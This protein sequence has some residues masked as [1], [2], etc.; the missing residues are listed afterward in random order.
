[1]TMNINAH[2]IVLDSLKNLLKNLTNESFSKKND[3][4]F[5]A[6]IGEHFRHIIEFYLCVMNQDTLEV[7]K[8]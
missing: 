7:N 2:I 3:L 4:L 8:L 1:M 5:G 6:S